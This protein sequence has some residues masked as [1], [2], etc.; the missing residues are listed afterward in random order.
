MSRSGAAPRQ[1]GH[2]H[3]A[4]LLGVAAVLTALLV[5]ALPDVATAVETPTFRLTPHPLEIQGSERRTFSFD[6][7][8][9]TAVSDSVM[10]Y[11]RSDRART[12]R[13][14]GADAHPDADGGTSISSFGA[15]RAVGSWIDVEATE[16]TL[17]P[18][19]HEIVDFTLSRPANVEASGMGAVVAEE[20]LDPNGDGGIEVVYRL[21]ILIELAG[22][23]TGLKVATPQLDSPIAL[24]PGTATTRT[25]VTN[26]TLQPVD[27]TVR[28]TVESLTGRQWPLEAVDVQLGAGETVPVQQLWSTMPRWG[29]FLGVSAEVTWEGGAVAAESP[30]RA[31]IPLW[32]LA[33][34]IGLVGVRA[35][36]ELRGS[37]HRDPTEGPG[38]GPNPASASTEATE[39]REPALVG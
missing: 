8:S 30:R 11:N 35:I 10:I 22:D 36:R 26:D 39:E 4:R 9:G 19:T 14:F 17:L 12:F 32:V 25:E 37:R 24:V 1:S 33:I 2:L 7:Q 18:R 3:V 23:A 16:V 31:F 34:V 15:A 28:F 27:A 6:L 20:I 38:D 13:V 29:G 21:A 5:V